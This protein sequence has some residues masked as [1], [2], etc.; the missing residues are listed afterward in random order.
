MSGVA[1]AELV[2]FDGVPLA[3]NVDAPLHYRAALLD[4]V[5]LV[6]GPTALSPQD[7]VTVVYVEADMEADTCTLRFHSGVRC[8]SCG[9]VVD[10]ELA[11]GATGG[12]RLTGATLW[13]R[14]AWCAD[15]LGFIPALPV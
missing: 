6:M 1:I 9:K 13:D 7:F 11:V 10:P 15:C 12:P 3:P 8:T 14:R 2:D 4:A 5:G